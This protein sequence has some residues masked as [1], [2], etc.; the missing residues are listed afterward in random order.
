MH[1]RTYKGPPSLLG[2]KALLRI[3]EEG[4]YRWP[5]RA[6]VRVREGTFGWTDKTGMLCPCLEL[7]GCIQKPCNTMT[8]II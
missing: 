6:A 8:K 5:E 3:T 1:P 2:E 4:S 7:T